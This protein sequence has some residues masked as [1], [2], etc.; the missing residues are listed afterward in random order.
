MIGFACA[1][2]VSSKHDMWRL[3]R[4]YDLFAEHGRGSTFARMFKQSTSQTSRNITLSIYMITTNVLFSQVMPT[5]ATNEQQRRQLTSSLGDG[6]DKGSR[7][8]SNDTMM[9]SEW[10]IVA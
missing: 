8:F 7:P 2:Q 1:Q 3:S 6:G 5:E 10:L 4:S 9:S